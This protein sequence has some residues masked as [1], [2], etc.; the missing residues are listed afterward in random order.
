VSEERREE[1]EITLEDL[2]AAIRIIEIFLARVEKARRVARR[3]SRELGGRVRPEDII[4]QVAL[5]QVLGRQA[6][7]EEVEEPE[8]SPEELER[9]RR[10]ARELA[11]RV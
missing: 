9:I 5:G 6:T 4:T 7:D 3:L 11:K 10:R 1:A 8:L 2:D